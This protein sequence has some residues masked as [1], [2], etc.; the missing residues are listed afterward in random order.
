MKI[1]KMYWPVMEAPRGRL[2]LP[3][4]PKAQP[5]PNSRESTMAMKSWRVTMALASAVSLLT[6]WRQRENMITMNIIQLKM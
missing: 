4:R 1:L 5:R 3:I 2:L 6:A